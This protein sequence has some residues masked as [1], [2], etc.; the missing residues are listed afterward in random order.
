MIPSKLN[1]VSEYIPHI[2]IY[3]EACELAYVPYNAN[4]CSADVSTMSCR[5]IQRTVSRYWLEWRVGRLFD[6]L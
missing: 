6:V 3:Y 5:A 2:K 4:I 1:S